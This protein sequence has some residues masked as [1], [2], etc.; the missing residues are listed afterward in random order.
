MDLR[1][2]RSFAISQGHVRSEQRKIVALFCAR[3]GWRPPVVRCVRAG[4][5]RALRVR[6]CRECAALLRKSVLRD[7]LFPLQFRNAVLQLDNL[8]FIDFERGLHSGNG[9]AAFEW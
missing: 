4:L 2:S 5:G 6:A 7:G 9:S 3:P 1:R 8:G